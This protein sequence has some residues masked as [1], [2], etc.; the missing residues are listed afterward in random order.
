MHI[1][2]K[3]D[4]MIYNKHYLLRLDVRA[5]IINNRTSMS[6]DFAEASALRFL[7]SLGKSFLELGLPAKVQTLGGPRVSAWP[8]ILVIWKYSTL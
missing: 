5:T 8:S 2:F 4:V 1:V 6:P 7:W 3:P